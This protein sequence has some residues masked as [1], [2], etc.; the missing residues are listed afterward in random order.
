MKAKQ[1]KLKPLLTLKW[2][3]AFNAQLISEVKES[4]NLLLALKLR[5]LGDKPLNIVARKTALN[6]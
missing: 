3:V 6:F 4:F 1:L 2:L 5:T